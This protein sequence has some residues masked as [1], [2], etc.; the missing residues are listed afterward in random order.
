MITHH[1]DLAAVRKQMT[2]PGGAIYKDLLK[3]GLLVETAAKKNLGAGPK[4]VN[5]GRLR[6]SITHQFITV[7]GMP[8]MIVG[9]NVVYAIY[10]HDGTGIYG[11]K[12]QRIHPKNKRAMRWKGK[13]VTG[14]IFAKSTAGMRPNPF[15][16]NALHAAKY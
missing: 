5:T 7:N 4:R 3:R 10:V 16:K 9:T 8:A 1:L 11:P 12:G 13:G 2:S 14:Y 15:L 6:A